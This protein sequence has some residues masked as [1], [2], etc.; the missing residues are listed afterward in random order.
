[1]ATAFTE[2]PVRDILASLARRYEHA[3]DRFVASV[4]RGEGVRSDDDIDRLWEALRQAETDLL[5]ACVDQLDSIV[6]ADAY[7]AWLARI[8]AAMCTRLHTDRASVCDTLIRIA[9]V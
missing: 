9:G 1:M 6:G 7:D 8:E 5:A 3:S 4:I 2:R